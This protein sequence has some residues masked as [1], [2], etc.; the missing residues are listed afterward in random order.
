MCA[1]WTKESRG[2]VDPNLLLKKLQSLVTLNP[3]GSYT[4]HFEQRDIEL[5]LHSL[6]KY[7][8][9][10]SEHDQIGLV[11]KAISEVIHKCLFNQK[12]FLEIVTIYEKEFSK[13]DRREFVV[14][15]SANITF[16]GSRIIRK[17]KD[18]LINI[19]KIIPN[20]MRAVYLEKWEESKH[21]IRAEFP[22][23]YAS[24][25]IKVYAKTEFEAFDKAIYNLNY[26]R[27]IWNLYYNHCRI[28]RMTLGSKSSGRINKIN[29]GPLFTIHQSDGSIAGNTWL[30]ED[31]YR[32]VEEL[33]NLSREKNIFQFER[34]IKSKIER[35]SYKEKLVKILTNY[36][37][38]LDIH[39][40]SASFIRLWQVFEELTDASK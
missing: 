5:A 25:L 23:K 6:I 10:L 34:I 14:I 15:T 3:D 13:L 32:G 19:R 28:R 11:K 30:I 2:E 20:K 33:I 1:E 8:K 22:K 7:S 26:I 29:N 37:E 24:I 21:S 4:W 12:D 27:S 31:T 9:V 40:T 39:E 38:A 18:S 36:N 17:F 35:S 16:N